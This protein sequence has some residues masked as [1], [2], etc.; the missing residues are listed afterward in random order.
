MT[1]S[2]FIHRAVISMCTNPE[3]VNI[4][5]ISDK[6]VEWA[7]SLADRMERDSVAEFD[8]EEEEPQE[9]VHTLISY[10]NDSLYDIKEAMGKPQKGE[11]LSTLQETVCQLVD[12]N[13]SLKQ[14]A[15]NIE[16]I[17]D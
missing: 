16:N 11:D 5:M 14:I 17:K 1:R 13:K 9:S 8:S 7:E 4:I 10:I 3:M 12:L 15:A 2:E 6:V